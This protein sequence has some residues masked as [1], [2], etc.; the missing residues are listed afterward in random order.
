LP[1]RTSSLRHEDIVTVVATIFK[2]IAF[3]LARGD[4]VELR[5]FGAFTVRRRAAGLVHNPENGETIAVD[6]KFAPFFRAGKAVG[7]RPRAQGRARP[8]A[9]KKDPVTNMRAEY[10]T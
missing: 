9:Q 5:G 3:V 1:P 7:H 10:V 4:R 2:E 8:H 6:E